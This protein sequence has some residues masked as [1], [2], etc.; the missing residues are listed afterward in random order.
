MELTKAQIKSMIEMTGSEYARQES[1][2]IQRASEPLSIVAALAQSEVEEPEDI[3]KLQGVMTSL[4]DFIN[5]EIR[6]M[7]EAANKGETEYSKSADSLLNLSYA[8]SLGL[9]TLPSMAVKYV[10]L[11]T[12]KGY[13]FLWGNENLTDVELEYFTK[14]TDFWDEKLGKNPRPLTWDHA[15]DPDFKSS[16]IIGQITDWGDD[17]VGRWYVAKLERSHKYRKAIDALIEKGVLG[18]SSDSAP[19]Y[20]RRVKTGKSTWLQ[21]WAWFAS[22]LTDTPAEPR[23]IGSLDVLKSLGILLPDTPSVEAWEWNKRRLQLLKFK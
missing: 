12:I 16:P 13:T 19:Q 7:G 15:Q 10:S 18:T 17:E 4:T 2:D 11:D 8:K 3:A 23:M 22:A 9:Q 21:E 6:E 20:V 1:W 5:G 14:D